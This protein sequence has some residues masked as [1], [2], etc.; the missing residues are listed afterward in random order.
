MVKVQL[1][2]IDTLGIKKLAS[3][4]WRF[5]GR[6]AGAGMAFVNILIAS[7]SGLV[8]AASAKHSAQNIA[9]NEIGRQAVMADPDW[10]GGNYLQ[11]KESSRLR[12][13]PLRV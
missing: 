3:V 8:L 10:C 13:L 4:C 11:Q 6:N 2:L 7:P 9:F 1:E 12:A 5:N